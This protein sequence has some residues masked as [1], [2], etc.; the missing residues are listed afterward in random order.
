MDQRV[1]G[2]LHN[3]NNYLLYAQHVLINEA[4]LAGN[5]E[6]STVQQVESH[7]KK[8]KENHLFHMLLS[9]RLAEY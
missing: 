2:I 8:W 3:L 9:Q 1:S 4:P 5:S 6:E 7:E